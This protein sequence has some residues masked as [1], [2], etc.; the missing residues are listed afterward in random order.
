MKDIICTIL[1]H[2]Q[3]KYEYDHLKDVFFKCQSLLTEK[4]CNYSALLS[5]VKKEVL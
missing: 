1:Y 5:Q 2:A 4:L 3:T